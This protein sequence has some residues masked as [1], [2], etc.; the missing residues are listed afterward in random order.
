MA[1]ETIAVYLYFVVGD[2][3]LMKRVY[4]TRSAEGVRTSCTTCGR[5]Y[6]E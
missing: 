5:D 6:Q 2:F 3:E 1:N 4:A